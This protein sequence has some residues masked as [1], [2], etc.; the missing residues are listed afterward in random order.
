MRTELLPAT[1]SAVRIAIQAIHAGQPI[2]MP[3]ET[4]YGL[5]AKAEDADAL[6][7]IFTIKARPRFNPLIVHVSPAMLQHNAYSPLQCLEEQGLITRKDL[8][9]AQEQLLSALMTTFWPG[10]LTLLF[11]RGRKVHDLVTAGLE[12][13]ALRMP[14]HPVAQAL[15]DASGQALAAPS[16]NRS[17][18]ISPTT[19]QHVFDDLEGH[20]PIVLDG[21]PC[22]QGLEST[23]LQ[24]DTETLHVLRRGSITTDMIR[25]CIKYSAPVQDAQ[26]KASA[27]ETAPLSSPGTLLKHYAP[28]TPVRLIN[29][30]VDLLSALTQQPET[31][32][33]FA[34]LTVLPLSSLEQE[35]LTQAFPQLKAQRSLS[36]STGGLDAAARCLFATLR[37]LDAQ[38]VQTLFIQPCAHNE[39]LAAAIND[40]LERAAG[41]VIP[42]V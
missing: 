39:G 32:H 25:V 9:Q 12:T 24:V 10:P 15:I 7:R 30:H 3:T 1:E 26:P 28:H 18:H 23:V 2:G 20:I 16:A 29:A 37:H 6:T 33:P 40:R 27:D 34:L 38:G 13:V 19:A 4:V 42:S 17:G 11:P 35:Q 41:H 36:Q 8:N 22:A 21:G 5:A 14:A 31:Q